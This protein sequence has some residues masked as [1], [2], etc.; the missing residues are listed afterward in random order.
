[1]FSLFKS[2]LCAFRQEGSSLYFPYV[3]VKHVTPREGP[4][5]A[6]GLGHNL[7][8]LGRGPLGH[9]TYQISRL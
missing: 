6:L 5:F 9:A 2:R 3:Y 4:F 7:N 8:K 1:M